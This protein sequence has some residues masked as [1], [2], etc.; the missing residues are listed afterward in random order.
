M[1]DNLNPT[2]V[3]DLVVRND[4]I[5][6][7][8]RDLCHG[9]RL[10]SRKVT[11]LRLSTPK[12]DKASNQDT[13]LSYLARNRLLYVDISLNDAERLLPVEKAIVSNGRRYEV[14]AAKD[15]HDEEGGGNLFGKKY[16][17]RLYYLE[18]E[19]PGVSIPISPQQL[20][21]NL[22]N[23]ESLSSRKVVSRLELFLSPAIALL[24][25]KKLETSD[26][27][28][29]DKYVKKIQRKYICDIPESGHIGCGFICE[30]LLEDILKGAPGVVASRAT[31]IQVRL[32]IPSMGKIIVKQGFHN[33]GLYFIHQLADS[34]IL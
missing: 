33:S 7:A 2:S 21:S 17:R 4:D 11:S 3:S 19:G 18:T 24:S 16:K 20:L 8:D 1:Y 14:I 12:S 31:C 25:D 22:A 32:F 15:H 28:L 13:F 6:I 29:D 10:G 9:M 23:F 5:F 30:D 27:P 26:N 34:L